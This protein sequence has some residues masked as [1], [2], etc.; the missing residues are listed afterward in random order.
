[1]NGYVGQPDNFPGSQGGTMGDGGGIAGAIINAGAGMYDSYKNRQQSKWNTKYTNEMQKREAELAYQRSVEMWHMQNMYN[2]PQAQM[3][4][5]KNAGLNPHLIYGQG[6][7]G[8]ASSAPE[9]QPANLQYRV[10]AAQYGAGLQSILPTLMAVGTW[11]Q[12]M[13]ASEVQIQKGST[14]TERARQLIDYLSQ[15]NPKALQSLQ[16]KLDLYPYQATMQSNLAGKAHTTLADLEQEFRYKWGDSLFSEVGSYGRQAAPGYGVMTKQDGI[17]KLQFLEQASKT[18]LAEARASWSDFDITNPQA[19][20][21]M[22]LSGVMGMAGMTLRQ[23]KSGPRVQPK[24]AGRPTGLRR[25]HPSRRV[26]SK[27]K[28]YYD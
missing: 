10:E 9:Y 13:R 3:A 27:P 15:A 5:F 17:K 19:I 24:S 8:N 28:G 20:I 4:R 16:N 23:G 1:M 2:D 22:V 18:K 21:Q 6:S 25:I 12:N 7:P 14:E 26:Q 11:M